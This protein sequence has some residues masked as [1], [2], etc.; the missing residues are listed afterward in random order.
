MTLIRFNVCMKLSQKELELD[1][2][3]ATFNTSISEAKSIHQC[4][5]QVRAKPVYAGPTV[6]AGG[7]GPRPA[8]GVP[9]PRTGNEA[10]IASLTKNQL[11]LLGL[12]HD[13][14]HK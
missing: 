1:F 13:D 8:Q 6:P 2:D 9:R 12:F 14:G 11:P 5:H 7:G 3:W 10:Q 4:I